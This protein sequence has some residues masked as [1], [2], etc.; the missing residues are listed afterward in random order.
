MDDAAMRK[1]IQDWLAGQGALAA[2]WE[3]GLTAI[4]AMAPENGGTGE[5]DKAFYIEQQLASLGIA[6]VFRVDAPDPRVPAGIRPNIVARIP[7]RSSQ[8]L[9]LMGHMDVVPPGDL[10]L[11]RHDPWA[12]QVDGDVI[13]G[14][15]VEDN[16]QAITSML[17]LAA[18]LRQANA[19]PDLTLG[20]L[21]VADEE[22]GSKYGMEYVMKERPD[23]FHPTDLVVVPDMGVE[24]G[25]L[26]EIAEKGSLWL[27][28]TV[29]G[30]QCHASHP[31]EGRNAL[32]AAAEMILHVNDAE[33]LFPASDPVF[34]SPSTFAP[35]RHEENIP[36]IN[37]VPGREVFYIDCRIL[38]CYKNNDVLAAFQNL[39]API[40]MRHGV[41]VDVE[42]VKDQ[43]ASPATAPDSPVV[44]R[45][46]RALRSL[47]SLE[48]RCIGVGGGTVAAVFRDKGV[49]AAAWA[50]QGGTMHQPN[51][52]SRLSRI[53]DDAKVFADMLFD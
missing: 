37:T 7:G 22:C 51:E 43:A 14:R 8:T 47:R 19:V 41:K 9:W 30:K 3:R 15:G 18:A 40:A 21:F 12:M 42:A 2:D 25:S 33:A 36:N 38:P 52:E 27:R 29:H 26:I 44:I 16:Q 20:L 31:A 11:W 28:V 6:D 39:F 48:S 53:L 13:S 1:Q 32:V 5:L 34:D 46:Q 4:P 10:A 24:D 49:P 50:T 45:L 35:T 17:L 23:L